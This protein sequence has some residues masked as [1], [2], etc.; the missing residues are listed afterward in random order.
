MNR[1]GRMALGGENGTVT[2][3]LPDLLPIFPV[4]LR[5]SVFTNS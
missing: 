4:L 1:E 5:F 2:A 3:K